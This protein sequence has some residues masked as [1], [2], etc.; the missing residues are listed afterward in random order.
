MWLTI[1]DWQIAGGF[2]LLASVTFPLGALC[3]VLSCD[4]HREVNDQLLSTFLAIGAGSLIFAVAVEVYA[5]G[6]DAIEY[7]QPGYPIRTAAYIVQILFAVAGALMYIGLER[8]VRKRRITLWNARGHT[9]RPLASSRAIEATSVTV[10]VTA[11]GNGSTE[12]GNNALL[13]ERSARDSDADMEAETRSCT[14]ASPCEWAVRDEDH[15]RVRLLREAPEEMHEDKVH[16]IGTKSE[17]ELQDEEALSGVSALT[18][19]HYCESH[20]EIRG[21]RDILHEDT[22]AAGAAA[23]P[24][25]IG[26]TCNEVAARNFVEDV[27]ISIQSYAPMLE[28]KHFRLACSESLQERNSNGGAASAGHF[29]EREC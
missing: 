19:G 8:S 6:L 26:T 2:A 3:G 9:A 27:L 13:C 5:E 15:E 25:G 4:R 28:H 24:T 20:R 22:S 7:I 10:S 17:A 12:H 16:Q 11:S 29:Q 14:V 21:H 1:P 23:A 18:E